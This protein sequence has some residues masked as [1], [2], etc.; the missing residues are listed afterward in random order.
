MKNLRNV[1]KRSTHKER[2]QLSHRQHLGLL[3]KKKDYV[4]RAK[5]Y[6]QKKDYLKSLEEKTRLRNEDEFSHKMLNSRVDPIT[7]KFRR[8]VSKASR[9]GHKGGSTSLRAEVKKSK[10]GRAAAELK[11]MGG[12]AKK[13]FDKTK[14]SKAEAIQKL[15]FEDLT[16]EEQLLAETSDIQY[17]STRLQMD[18]KKSDRLAKDLHM[19]GLKDP[20][21]KHVTFSDSEDDS[22]L[23]GRREE[24]RGRRRGL[25]RGSKRESRLH[26]RSRSRR[27]R[28]TS[29]IGS[30]IT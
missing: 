19:L 4:Q 5:N 1:V 18:L 25:R 13:K 21:Q 29:S 3:E 12:D 10:L 20:S 8:L 7:G 24:K 28:R 11:A 15:H 30:C 16:K 27:G 17:V 14:L 9:V 22:V 6:H 23:L 26:R 2:H